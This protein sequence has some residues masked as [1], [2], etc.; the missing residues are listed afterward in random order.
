VGKIAEIL[1]MIMRAFSRSRVLSGSLQSRTTKDQWLVLTILA[2]VVSTVAEFVPAI[3]DESTAIGLVAGLLA[4]LG[5]A[6][7][8]MIR[9]DETSVK[10]VPALS[11]PSDLLIVDNVDL[12]QRIVRVRGTGGG[13]WKE[14]KS[15]WKAAAVAG[16]VQGV[17][18]TGEVVNLQNGERTGHSMRLPDDERG[19]G[20]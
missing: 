12:E 10:P 13:H 7:S 9:F 17:L 19:A 16:W 20:L 11:I 18:N 4:L 8:R 14:F 5:P 2:F 1:P 6:I 3:A 15:T